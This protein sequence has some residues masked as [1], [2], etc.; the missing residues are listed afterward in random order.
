MKNSKG[1]ALVIILAIIGGLVV[2]YVVAA[3]F[4]LPSVV[5][6]AVNT[7]I[8]SSVNSL[9]FDNAQSTTVS[10]QITSVKG[11]LD[12]ETM[13]KG[14]INIDGKSPNNQI[15]GNIKYLGQK[16]SVDYQVKTDSRVEGSFGAL[17]ISSSDQAGEER[18]LHFPTNLETGFMITL[19]AGKADI[20]LSNL[21]TPNINLTTGAGVVDITFPK[22]TS[23]TANLVAGAGKLNVSVYKGSGIK[24]KFA[25]GISNLA[26]GDAYEKVGDGYQTK[27]YDNAKVKV[28][29][30]VGQAVGGFNI[31][32]IE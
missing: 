2:L 15:T 18:T 7:A 26:L 32:E 13:N 25:Q 12:T 24:I 23:I 6:K 17:T 27:G 19:G 4:I 30:N 11:I 22:T 28:E 3:K 20:D 9:N 8:D 16:P 5:N 29:L 21:N 10:Q 14:V 31:Q 1:N